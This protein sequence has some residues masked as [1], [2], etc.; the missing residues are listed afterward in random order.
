LVLLDQVL[1]MKKKEFFFICITALL[2][3]VFLVVRILSS[4][5]WNPHA[6]ILERPR[7]IPA[8]QT[9]G[10]GYDGR[11][12]YSLA[13]NPWGSVEGLDQP[14]FRY[15]RIL[16]PL[17]ARILSMNNPLLVPWNMILINLVATALLC[18]A[19]AYL[20]KQRG[21]SSWLSL[22]VVFSLGYLLTIRMDLNEPL[23]LGLALLGWVLYEKD[24]L[25]LAIILFALSGLTKEIGLIFPIALSVW[26]ALNKNWSRSLALGLGSV[27]PYIIWY[28]ILFNWFG[29]SQVQADQ[30]RPILIPFWGIK[31][32]KN[33]FSQLVVGLWVLIPALIAG[34]LSA[35]DLWGA[36]YSRPGRD[37]LL[38]LSHVGLIAVLPWP[39]WEDP[40]AILRMGIGL[41]IAILV[42]LAGARPR[43]IPYAVALWIPSALLLLFIPN[44]L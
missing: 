31:Y 29:I 22:T 30:S 20:L 35:L 13:T 7:D 44:M 21:A 42:W 40:I 24:K 9:W 6:F 12:T 8:T 19:L 28:G 39:T 36:K 32:L 1:R 25:T 37:A 10:V 23:A 26:E 14:A 18:S 34:L 2:I 16:F 43:L 27:A 41:Q 3:L 5:E 15:Q 33:P 11:F 17:L 4:H 38:V